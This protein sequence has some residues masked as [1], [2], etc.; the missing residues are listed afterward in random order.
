VLA[1]QEPKPVPVHLVHPE[2]RH[3]A[4]KVRA[5]VDFAAAQLRAHPA[6]NDVDP[7]RAH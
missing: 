3:A 2:G 5:F 7:P 6:L 4:A 1:A